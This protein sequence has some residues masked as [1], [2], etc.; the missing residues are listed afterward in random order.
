MKNLPDKVTAYLRKYA[1]KQWRVE[2]GIDKEFKNIIIIPSL[3]ELNNLKN[4]LLSLAANENTYFTDTL[5]LI[6]VNNNETASAEVKKDNQNTIE[7]LCDILSNSDSDFAA[8]R[9]SASGLNIAFVDASTT[10]Y[11]MPSKVGGVG[12][13]RKIGMDLSLPLFAYDTERNPGKN[14]MIC[15]DADCAVNK[16]YINTIVDNFNSSSSSVAVINYEHSIEG[17]EEETYAIICYE[18]FLRY[19]VMGLSFAGSPYAFHTIGSAMACD[20]D[21]YIKNEGMNKRKAAEDFYFLEKLSKNYRIDTIRDAYVYPSRRSSWRVPFG[22]GQR[23]T[24]YLSGEQEEYLLLNPVSFE[25]LKYWLFVF[26]SGDEISPEEY[27]ALAEDIEPELKNF[28]VSQN[29]IDDL[30]SII[31]NSQSKAQMLKQ[32]RKWFD[33]F[34]TLKLMHYLRDTAFPMINMFDALDKLFNMMNSGISIER[35]YPVPGIEIQKK[36]LTELRQSENK[37][38]MI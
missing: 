30:R 35:K 6:V 15:L 13:A 20:V 34:K 17:T 14:I 33:G 22:T 31:N 28:L 32:K 7:F 8:S 1:S 10:G 4:C 2:P 5:V 9:I 18:I 26:D 16:N 3:A 23:V 12:L 27:L 37:S 36:Y 21:S 38:V 29:F 25:I 19:Y 11:E 24:R